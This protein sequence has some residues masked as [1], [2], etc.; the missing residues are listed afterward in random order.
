MSATS[1]QIVQTAYQAFATRD[2]AKLLSLFSPE[3][4]IAQSTELPWGGAFR[5]H[6][7]AQ[8]FFGTLTKHINST[9]EIERWLKLRR[10]C[11]GDW[12]DDGNSERD[13]RKMSR[14]DSARL[15]GSRWPGPTHSV[16]D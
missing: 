9:L 14:A 7:G 3:I 16:L 1:L 5:G 6:N 15:E 4:E 13:R 10:P 8:Q 11:G 12:P 2:A